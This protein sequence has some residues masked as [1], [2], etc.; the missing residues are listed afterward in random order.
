MGLTRQPPD[1]RGERNFR[2]SIWDFRFPA[3][4]RPE[5]ENQKSKI[6]NQKFP[7]PSTDPFWRLWGYVRVFRRRIILG[8]L[9][10]VV[11]SLIL[12]GIAQMIREMQGAM[13]LQDRQLITRLAIGAVVVYFVQGLFHFGQVYLLSNVA[14]RLAQRLR[15]DLYEHL[16]TLSLGFFE[17]RK[18]GGLMAPHPREMSRLPRYRGLRTQA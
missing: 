8:C 14:E 3:A 11:V 5:F 10:G 4:R 7:S 2:F 17:S 12:L 16:Q 18:T 15:N 1:G 9:C 6:K 13:D